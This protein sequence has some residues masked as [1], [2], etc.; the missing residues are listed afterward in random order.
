MNETKT[1]L[2]SDDLDA[3]NMT[4]HINKI[5]TNYIDMENKILRDKQLESIDNNFNNAARMGKTYFTVD[6]KY[7]AVDERK[8]IMKQISDRF[9]YI[10]IRGQRI[11]NPL[12]KSSIFCILIPNFILMSCNRY[13]EIKLVT[14]IDGNDTEYCIAMTDE[15]GKDILN[16]LNDWLY[17]WEGL[18]LDACCC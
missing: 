11:I 4:E 18:P 5:R 2:F 3:D 15:A 17:Y 7:F 10:F 12:W 9:N 14:D 8:I 6:L 16:G 1:Y 13:Y